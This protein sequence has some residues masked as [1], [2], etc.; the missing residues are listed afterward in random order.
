M[1]DVEIMKGFDIQIK[2]NFLEKK[3]FEKL[4]NRLPILN[5]SAQNERL[6]YKSHVWFSTPCDKEV[7]K[8]IKKKCENILNKKLKTDICSYTLVGSQESLPHCDLSDNHEY[9]II[10]YIKGNQNLHKGTGFY[11]FNEESK[12]YELN[13]HIGFKENRAVI[14]HSNSWHSPM[15]WASEDKSSRYSVIGMYKEKD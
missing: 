10:I 4:K 5:Y 2:D 11:V 9:Q 3:L 12:N 14:W 6:S 7:E 15:C 13:T 1:D 8:I